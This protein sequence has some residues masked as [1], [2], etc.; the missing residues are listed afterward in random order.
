MRGIAVDIITPER[1]D[2]R[3]LDWAVRAHIAPLIDAG[4]RLWSNPPPFN[5]AKL[6]TVDASWCLIGSANWDL[7]SFRLNFELNMEVYHSDLVGQIDAL[8]A[9][10]QS[11]RIT[12]ADLER[13][14]LPIR[15]RD[16]AARLMLPY[17]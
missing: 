1:S 13:R 11:R 10:K 6:M 7:R 2:H 15:L 4:C 5:H 3:V 16:N 8:M 14:S 12:P 17:L 9:A